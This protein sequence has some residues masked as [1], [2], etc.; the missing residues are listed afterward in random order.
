V[1]LNIVIG[2]YLEPELV[3]FIAASSD[4]LRVHFR[5]DL[6]PVPR[7]SCDHSAPP[8]DLTAA[9]L[10]EWRA[11]AALAD[12]FFDFD[13]LDPSSM[14]ER[15][16]NLKWIQGTSA[17]IGGLMQRTGLDQSGITVTTAGG[18]HAV[19][20]AEFALMG[21]L[22]F[23]K[24]LPHLTKCK[25]EHHWQRYTTRQLRGM[26]ALVVGLGGMGRQIVRQFSDQGVTVTGLGRTGGVYEI[27]GLSTL[28]DRSRLDEVLVDTDILVLSCP[29]TKETEGIIGEH[30]LGLLPS[31][32]IV[33]N[34]SRGQLVDQDALLRSLTSGTLGGACL[35]V[36]VEEPLP[37]DSQFWDLENVII[38]PHSASTVQT[39]NESLV[40]LLL[41]N[42]EHWRNGEP[43]R[44]L[45]DSVAGY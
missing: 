16:V 41:E 2:S 7:Y 35:D 18:I 40:R 34:V 32:A 9:Q 29:L 10:D 5:P 28:I 15:C 44:N 23:V 1:T 39:E 43:M 3:D 42:L 13:W 11:M 26:R 12:V 20:L 6:L 36:F 30:Q 8:R 45:Y 14:P 22:Y 37:A 31:N 38:S 27:E 4:D 24:G 19:P 17:G 33:I 25:N 21:A